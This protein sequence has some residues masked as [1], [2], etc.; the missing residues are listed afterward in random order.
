MKTARTGKKPHK[1]TLR[2]KPSATARK[3]R[4]PAPLRIST[5]K[6]HAAAKSGVPATA[7]T[8]KSSPDAASSANEFPNAVFEDG[9][10]S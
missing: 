5:A 10:R 4:G 9:R 1:Q 6:D 7:K 8:Q 2:G 3:Q